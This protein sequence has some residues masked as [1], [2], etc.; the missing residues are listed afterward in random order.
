MRLLASSLLALGLVACDKKPDP[1]GAYQGSVHAG[2]TKLISKEIVLGGANHAPVSVE[3]LDDVRFKV[4]FGECWAIVA[5]P[6][7]KMDVKWEFQEGN[8]CTSGKAGQV[9]ISEGF[10]QTW[11]LDGEQISFGFGG[12]NADSTLKVDFIFAPAHRL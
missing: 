5:R 7:E 1:S 9:T 6:K 3:R 12:I 8:T 4:H 11:D 2:M 10:M